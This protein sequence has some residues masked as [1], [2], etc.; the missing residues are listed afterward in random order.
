MLHLCQ[1]C[2]ALF[3]FIMCSRQH[4]SLRKLLFTFY[5][6]EG[7][8]DHID[9]IQTIKDLNPVWALRVCTNPTIPRC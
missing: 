7:H 4:P 2:A 8:G 9:R 6:G 5:F 1:P 3:T